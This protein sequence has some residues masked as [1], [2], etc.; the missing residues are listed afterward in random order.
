MAGPLSSE[1]IED[2]VSSVRRLVSNEHSARRASHDLQAERLLLTPA[3]RVVSEIFPKP[4][5]ILDAP[6]EPA[7]ADAVSDLSTSDVPD[8]PEETVEL[9]EAEWE[10][11]AIWVPEAPVSLGE[12]ALAADEAEV[13]DA[14]PTGDDQ[15]VLQGPAD[16]EIKPDTAEGHSPVADPIPFVPLRRRS[17]H[18]S[19]RLPAE[20]PAD[21]DALPAD[22]DT[23][24]D[25]SDIDADIDLH[26]AQTEMEEQPDQ[27]ASD[28]DLAGRVASDRRLETEILDAD[29]TPLAVLDEAALQEIVRLMIREELQ[30]DL[31]ERITRNVRKLVRAEINRA[32][33]ARDLD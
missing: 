3:L 26:L 25:Q 31:G 15:H 14:A 6:L 11:E 33:V 7:A 22:E 21:I 19:S 13:L 30:G 29:G 20:E 8:Q 9:V 18:L 32:L 23:A 5:L 1:E 27:N 28:P 10:D 24:V 12:V 4:P 17:E 2:V 16:D